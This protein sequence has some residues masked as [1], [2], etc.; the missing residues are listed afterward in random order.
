MKRI[1]LFVF[2]FVSISTFAQF[3]EEIENEISIRKGV[4]NENPSGLF[5]DFFTSENFN[6]SHSVDMSYST[7]GGNGVALGVY[8]NTMAF[9]FSDRL[10][11]EVD[12]SL[13]NT[14]YNSYGD[15]FTKSVN[16]IYLSRAQLNYKLSEDSNI[17]LIYR[18]VPYSRSYYYSPFYRSRYY[19]P[20]FR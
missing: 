16:G 3:K 2:L 4:F 15:E 12:A 14:P 11:L 5:L 7:F 10:H 1:L 17:T 18:Q 9:Q 19:E 8:T 13:V 20:Y 6:M